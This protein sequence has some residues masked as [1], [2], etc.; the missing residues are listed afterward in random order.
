MVAAAE[1]TAG[2]GVAACSAN[3][4]PPSDA[5]V[6][7]DAGAAL[8]RSSVAAAAAAGATWVWT[9]SR[10]G[11]RIQ[12]VDD[13]DRIVGANG[14]VAIDVQIGGR[15]AGRIRERPQ[16]VRSV[17]VELI[18][19]RHGIREVDRPVAIDVVGRD[20]ICQGASVRS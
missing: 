11:L 19:D 6:G 9:E 10:R 4:M 12:G 1:L 7:T 2:A 15:A 16:R 5:A 14:A 8:A 3:A 20:R 13:Q 17:G 18:N